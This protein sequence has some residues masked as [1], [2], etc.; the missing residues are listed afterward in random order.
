VRVYRAGTGDLLGLSIV[1]TGSGYN[2]QNA[3][4][5]HFG[6]RNYDP[7]DIRVTTMSPDGP[8]Y[9]VFEKVS[10]RSLAGKPFIARTRN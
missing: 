6:L 5:V 8:Q 3:K 10:P 1:D 7:V 4:P 9:T 2:A